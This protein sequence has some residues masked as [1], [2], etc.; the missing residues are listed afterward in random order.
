MIMEIGI[1]FISFGIGLFAGSLI[2]KAKNKSG[3]GTGALS[4]WLE[5]IKKKKER[6]EA[7]KKFRETI[8]ENARAEALKQMQ[9][10]L[11]KH[12]IEEERK[13]LTGEDKKEKLKKFADAFSMGNLGT[14]EKLNKM[15]GN[16]NQPQTPTYAQPP[17]RPTMPRQ[18][19]QRYSRAQQQ[20]QQSTVESFDPFSTDKLNMMM[21]NN[22]SPQ[23]KAKEKKA[24]ADRIKNLLK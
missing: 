20:P 14:D 24:E 8:K 19:Q 21:G 16:H 1:G 10:E 12:M 18:P 11:V 5:N 9:P 13:K 7:E 17:P 2:E 3:D 23:Q 6:K 4:S 22:V 15:L